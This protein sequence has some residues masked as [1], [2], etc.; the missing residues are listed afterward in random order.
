MGRFLALVAIVAACGGGHGASTDGGNTGS[1]GGG[2]DGGIVTAPPT[3]CSVPAGGMLV[4]TSASTNVVTNCSTAGLQAAVNAGGMVRFDC[5][6]GTTT[7]TLDAPITIDNMAGDIVIDGGSNVILDGGGSNRIIVLDACTNPISPHCDSNPHP[8]VTLERLELQHAA[9]SSV[10]GGGAVYRKGGAL[11]VIDCN[12]H[13]NKCAT[14]GQ[15]TAGGALRL[16]YPTP[17]LVVGS[18]FHNNTCS[19]GGAIGTLNASPVQVINSVVDGNSATGTGGNPGN[20]GN[21][22]GFYHDGAMIDVEL[23]GVTITNNHAN[24]FGGG[25]FYVDDAGKGTVNMTNVELDGNQIPVVSGMPSHGGGGYVQGANTTL[26]NMTIAAN[27]AGFAAGLYVNTMNNLGSLNATNLTVTGMTGDGLTLA[28]GIAGTL[29]DATIANN[30]SNG[31]SGAGP[32]TLV[33]SILAGNGKQCD[34]KPASAM[35]SIENG[36]GTCGATAAGDPL[37]GPVQDNGGTTGI[38]TMAPGAGSPA[39]TAATAGC[40]ATDARGMPRPMTGC[41]AGAHEGH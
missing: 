17:T 8:A 38:H 10:D 22:G 20:G 3:T 7:I 2:S 37:L 34:A 31:I 19:D 28:G 1:N 36:A 5:G 4:D 26:A 35:G 12:F 14:T 27:A 29:L 30:T 23:C 13:D 33:N 40:P 41:T 16:I 39:L 18:T 25:I 21:G 24:A 11:T 15:D 6:S 9:D 32:M